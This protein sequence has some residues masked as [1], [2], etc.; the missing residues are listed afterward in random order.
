MRR[1]IFLLALGFLSAAAC[2]FAA[3]FPSVT[4]EKNGKTYRMT[5]GETDLSAPS[6][7]FFLLSS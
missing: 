6:D 2:S 3:D 1:F 5:A 4:F 7:Q